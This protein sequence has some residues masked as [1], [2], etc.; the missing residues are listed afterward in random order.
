MAHAVNRTDDPVTYDPFAHPDARPVWSMN[1]K[2]QG[3][4]VKR[5]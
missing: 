2:L 4:A 5:A 1:R 3:Q